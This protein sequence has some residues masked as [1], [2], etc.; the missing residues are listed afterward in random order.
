MGYTICNAATSRA[1]AGLQAG[2]HNDKEQEEQ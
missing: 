2:W 1:L